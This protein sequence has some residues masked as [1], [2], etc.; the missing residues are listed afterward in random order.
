MGVSSRWFFIGR[1][2][3]AC[4][5][6]HRSGGW[7]V[8]LNALLCPSVASAPPFWVR[9]LSIDMPKLHGWTSRARNA[10]CCTR[11]AR[12]VAALGRTASVHL[13]A[14]AHRSID[15]TDGSIGR[16]D[17]AELGDCLASCICGGWSIGHAASTDGPCRAHM[18]CLLIPQADLSPHTFKTCRKGG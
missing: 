8:D 3:C 9:D 11:R 14:A 17:S 7:H 10:S 15:C 6:F 2:H 16:V 18:A 4:T 12:G 13:A 1:P 5:P